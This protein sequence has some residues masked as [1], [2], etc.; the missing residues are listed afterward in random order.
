MKSKRWILIGIWLTFLAPAVMAAQVWTDELA[1]VVREHS[2]AR[3][4][5][6]S[7]ASRDDKRI[8]G[9]LDPACRVLTVK[10][11]S[12]DFIRGFIS[13]GSVKG[14]IFF[15]PRI[16]YF[17]IHSFGRRTAKDLYR[18]LTAISSSPISGLVIDLRGNRGGLL[19]SAR[20]CMEFWIPKGQI[21]L[22]LTDK[23][24]RENIFVSKNKKPL[25]IVT[26][27]LVDGQTASCAEAFAGCLAAAKKAKLVG[28]PTY[29]KQ[30]V[31]EAFPLDSRH[32]LFLTTGQYRI[33][34]K[35]GSAVV[36]EML[37]HQESKQLKTALMLLQQATGALGPDCTSNRIAS[38][39]DRRAVMAR[40]AVAAPQL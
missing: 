38:R 14:P 12:L 37:V 7:L 25:D 5:E 36:P 6:A 16:A 18:A 21:Y 31:Q 27:L 24:G 39:E 28:M 4:S 26:V 29:G 35:D 3:V 1:K 17:K 34:G 23:D 30:T 8:L 13:E 15:H 40:K 19:S 33:P 22:T 11:A 2:Y 32:L 20:E 10:P 9:Q